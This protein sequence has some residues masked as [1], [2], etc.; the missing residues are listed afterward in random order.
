VSQPG[1]T[2]GGRRLVAAIMVLTALHHVDHLRRGVSGWPV[3]GPF[4]PFSASLFVYAVVPAA[5]LASAAG[6]IGSRFWAVLAAGGAVFVTVVHV[7]PAAGDEVTA[8]RG[9]Y[10]SPVAA[11]GAVVVLAGLLAALVAHAAVE[12]RRSRRR[13]FRRKVYR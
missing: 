1:L 3:D 11:A 4:T 8:I 13:V 6:R 2:T 7:G 12:I 9:G 10:G 5:V